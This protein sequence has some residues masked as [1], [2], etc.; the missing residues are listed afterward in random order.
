M[1]IYDSVSER[2]HRL[3]SI[4]FHSRMLRSRDRA[5]CK[6]FYLSHAKP[7]KS[8]FGLLI[9]LL[10]AMIF[11]CRLDNDI[12]IL[13]TTQGH[14]PSRVLVATSTVICDSNKKCQDKDR[15][16]LISFKNWKMS[17]FEILALVDDKNHCEKLP[18]TVR[19]VQHKCHHKVL[20]LPMVGCLIHDSIEEN[21]DS[22][23]VFSNDDIYFKGLSET[24]R[25]LE[26]SFYGSFVAFGRRTNVPI[27]SF[28]RQTNVKDAREGKDLLSSIQIDALEQKNFKKGDEFE[29]DYF[30]FKLQATFLD[31][32]PE[33]VFGN[34]RWD[35]VL[36]DYLIM[37]NISSVDVSET[38]TAYHIGK[39]VTQNVRHGAKFNNDAMHEYFRQTADKAT[40]MDVKM[41]DVVR[42]G[43]IGNAAYQT[44]RSEDD[45]SIYVV[46]KTNLDPQSG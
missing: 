30:V 34:W 17:G 35:N 38:V 19:C 3:H 14:V 40:E 24:I 43:S 36:I 5:R 39:S 28:M 10:I 8:I 25:V 44:K 23:I 32:Y 33:F 7:I 31:N 11:S 13:S 22:I 46:S 16:R 29:V 21:S 2:T 37:H 1:S 15:A 27:Q 6:L 18:T 9:L 12:Y 26:H 45:N 41:H 20:K 42:F 4:D